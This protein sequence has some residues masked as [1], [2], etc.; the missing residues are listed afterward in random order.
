[1]YCSNCGEKLEDDWNICPYCKIKI[2]KEFVQEEVSDSYDEKKG[3]M[4]SPVVKKVSLSYKVVI[5]FVCAILVVGM[6]AYVTIRLSRNKEVENVSGSLDDNDLENKVENNRM[7]ENNINKD[8]L[9]DYDSS[10]DLKEKIA[11]DEQNSDASISL[12]D[13]YILP[14]SSSR[15]LEGHDIDEIDVGKLQLAINEIYARHGRKFN[16]PTIQEYFNKMS[17]YHGT[18]APEEF[19]EDILSDIE[20]RNITSI[21]N[22][23]NLLENG[24]EKLDYVVTY[25]ALISNAAALANNSSA[26]YLWD[27]D[28]DGVKELILKEG[29]SESD[30]IISF[31]TYSDGY[32]EKIGEISGSH[33]TPCAVQDMDGI[34]IETVYM[35][36]KRVTR[37]LKSEKNIYS[38]IVYEEE[39]GIDEYT[40][41]PM[42]GCSVNS[43]QLLESGTEF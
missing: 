4:I 26:Y 35:G 37:I 7:D 33:S 38:E 18:I 31:Y 28:Q 22:R 2:I 1:M 19:N 32:S 23:L 20:K 3:E 41:F 36:Y 39:N 24:N 43:F 10:N 9:I 5:G 25:G 42:E 30:Y 16:D 34:E 12:D 15:I 8:E 13:I 27:I 40:C 6:M 17:W 29:T 11:I 21:K 14:D